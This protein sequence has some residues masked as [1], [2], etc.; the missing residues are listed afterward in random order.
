VRNEVIQ[1]HKD[2]YIDAL[3]KKR[4]PF[5]E[6]IYNRNLR[7]II[8]KQETNLT[9]NT[10][11]A[12]STSKTQEEATDEI[13]TSSRRS[14]TN[15]QDKANNM[16]DLE[17]HFSQNR[18]NEAERER[19][20]LSYDSSDDTDLNVEDNH[21]INNVNKYERLCYDLQIVPCSIII[22]SLPTT[23]IS[24]S[25]Y[26]L[27]STGILALSTTLKVNYS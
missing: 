27:N 2:P 14:S 21:M 7:P 10:A 24:L 20:N 12:Q 18:H 23:A 6:N 11:A 9:T 1:S 8:D 26:G 16:Y 15:S 19:A 17:K 25:N 3:L 5:I 22:K 13:K 4:Q